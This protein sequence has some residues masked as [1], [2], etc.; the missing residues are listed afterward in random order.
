[1]TREELWSGETERLIAE[2]EAERRADPKAF[3][4]P[5]ANPIRG[6]NGNARAKFLAERMRLLLPRVEQLCRS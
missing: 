1:V 2:L 6:G 3:Y 5:P 4:R